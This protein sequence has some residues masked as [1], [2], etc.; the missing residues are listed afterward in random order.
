M[1]S[2]WTAYTPVHTPSVN[3]RGIF[4]NPTS[5]GLNT[6]VDSIVTP[7]P[8]VGTPNNQTKSKI[9]QTTALSDNIPEALLKADQ[10]SLD[11]LLKYRPSTGYED[12][13]I[14]KDVAPLVEDELKQDNVSFA[15]LEDYY[16]EVSLMDR[17]NFDLIKKQFMTDPFRFLA[18]KEQREYAIWFCSNIPVNLLDRETVVA[19]WA[20]LPSFLKSLLPELVFKARLLQPDRPQ[21]E[22]FDPK[23]LLTGDGLTLDWPQIK[24]STKMSPYPLSLKILTFLELF[25]RAWFHLATSWLNRVRKYINNKEGDSTLQVDSVTTAPALSNCQ[26]PRFLARLQDLAKRDVYLFGAEVQQHKV[27]NMQYSLAAPSSII[28]PSTL[29]R[30]YYYFTNA[31]PVHSRREAL[32][33]LEHIMQHVF[34]SSLS[35]QTLREFLLGAF[36]FISH[37]NNRPS[38]N[39]HL[40]FLHRLDAIR[41]LVWHPKRIGGQQWMDY[42]IYQCNLIGLSDSSVVY[43]VVWDT[44]KRA[45]APHIYDKIFEQKILSG[46]KDKD[47]QS[48]DNAEDALSST[49]FS[50]SQINKLL[51]YGNVSSHSAEFN[52]IPFLAKDSHNPEGI[53]LTRGIPNFFP[54]VAQVDAALHTVHA[55]V[56]ITTV[57]TPKRDSEKNKQQHGSKATATTT[58]TSTAATTASVVPNPHTPTHL[59]VGNYNTKHDDIRAAFKEHVKN[60]KSDPQL[61][62]NFP[63]FFESWCAQS[64]KTAQNYLN[65]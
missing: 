13:F 9:T 54:T 16:E 21:P 8:S 25:W 42:I 39:S 61:K 20:C 36:T 50:P 47:S 24:I 1:A 26:E 57:V 60:N 29:A 37:N 34:A 41:A 40:T 53:M 3:I 55:G 58:T 23:G 33:W 44:M 51:S 35:P 45:F 27:K 46:V 30:W 15:S 11:D 38:N 5:E 56:A 49:F 10:V 14:W 18:T 63:R 17:E 64:G 32:S 2:T 48:W 43:Q 7:D 31:G 22:N 12:S 62:R 52:A 65:K 6:L 28:T 4:G 59:K 19:H